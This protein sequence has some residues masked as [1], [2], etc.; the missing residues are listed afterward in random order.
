MSNVFKYCDRRGV[1]I[2]RNLELKIT[3][4][5]QLNDVFE[6]SPHVICSAPRRMAKDALRDKTTVR[7]S[8]HD[9]KRSGFFV[10]TEREYRRFWKSKRKTLLSPLAA[11]IVENLPAV[12][13]RFPRLQSHYSGLLCLTSNPDSV[14][15]WSHYADNHRG[16]VVEFDRSWHLFA[17]GKGLRPVDYVHERPKWDEAVAEGSEAEKIQFDAVIFHKNQEWSYESE[18][19]QLFLLHGLKRRLNNAHTGYFLSIPPDASVHGALM[20]SND[21][22][23]S[24]HS[25]ESFDHWLEASVS[26]PSPESISQRLK[27]LDE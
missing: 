11:G 12:Q 26:V 1:D 23:T 9:D 8:Y 7:E 21:N 17:E 3:P 25:T 18:L 19:R 5:D 10:G 14:V 15:M 13:A 4:A 16:I 27:R 24:T 6:F 20:L 22:L 2:L